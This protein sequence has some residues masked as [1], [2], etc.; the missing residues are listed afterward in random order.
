MQQL[1]YAALSTDGDDPLS[2][3]TP[4]KVATFACGIDGCKKV[5]K[6]GREVARHRK[7]AHPDFDP[8]TQR[9]RA[10]KIV[11]REEA[12]REESVLQSIPENETMPEK[13][14][15]WERLGALAKGIKTEKGLDSN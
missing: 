4:K 15:R 8:E 7:H 12:E 3:T 10:G 11:T 2:S 1:T 13:M 9:V 5:F 6:R 14:A